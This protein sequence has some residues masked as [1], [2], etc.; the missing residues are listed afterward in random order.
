MY[1]ADTQPVKEVKIETVAK[2]A[3]DSVKRVLSFLNLF[4][5]AFLLRMSCIVEYKDGDGR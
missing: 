3:Y 5:D 2:L 4:N 1:I